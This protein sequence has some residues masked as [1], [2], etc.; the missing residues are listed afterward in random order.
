MSQGLAVT[1]DN[2]DI[3]LERNGLSVPSTQLTAAT[4]YEVVARVW[5]GSVDAPAV[6]L[7][8]RF[9][10]LHFGIGTGTV[11][12]GE[13][14]IDLPVKGAPGTPAFARVPWTT[15]ATP[16]HYCLQ[17]ELI[18]PDDANPAN[19]LGQENTDVKALNSP[20]AR[21]TFPVANQT[22]RG[23]TLKLEPDAYGIPP[24][25]PCRE[26]KSAAGPK[27]SEAEVANHRRQTLVQHGRSAH[28]VPKGWEVRIDPAELRL[29]PGEEQRVNVD[30]TAPEGFSGRQALN[31]NA[32]EGAALYGG[33]TL[34][35]EG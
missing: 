33:V 2:P 32:F 11:P 28:G 24:R 27:M 30:V 6:N 12:V 17:V 34:F 22:G 14:A 35:V 9:S 18:W 25:R 21:F 26:R 5:N 3:H 23:V 31:V 1:W 13:T 19:N 29:S 7:P 15:P 10:Y 8:V 4:D 20:R 16:G